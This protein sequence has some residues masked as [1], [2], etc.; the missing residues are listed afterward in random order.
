[1]SVLTSIP[2]NSRE[3]V[4]QCISS[5]AAVHSLKGQQPNLVAIVRVTDVNQETKDMQSITALDW[6]TL[7]AL[8]INLNWFIEINMSAW[9]N[10]EY[11][12]QAA[13]KNA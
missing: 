1:M 2:V 4:Y 6:I 5:T 12:K 8:K 9:K 3:N 10:E 7:V 13:I 11:D